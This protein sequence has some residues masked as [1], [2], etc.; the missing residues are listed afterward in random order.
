MLLLC[1]GPDTF[2]AQAKAQELERAFR[3]KY[4]PDGSS[5]EILSAGK[6]AWA[7]IME[8]INTP[9][10]FS[11]RRFLRTRDL[12]GNL[13]KTQ[14]ESLARALSNDAER[15]IVVSIESDPL[16]AKST[17]AL[18]KV[19]KVICY[20]FPLLK[21][22]EFR[23]WLDSIAKT[24]AISNEA[25][26]RQ[27]AEAA[28]GDGWLAWNELLKVAAGGQTFLAP[29]LE[30]KSV[31]EAADLFLRDVKS[32]AYLSESDASFSAIAPAFLSQTRAAIRVR[33]GAT[34]GL[35]PYVVKKLQRIPPSPLEPTL[36]ALIKAM[37]SQR[38][39][40]GTDSDVLPILA[41]R[42]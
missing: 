10:L 2:R 16:S 15:V 30:D 6:E 34:D 22:E 38:S 11:P 20:D 28:D 9:S 39:G 5:V 29:M 27:I 40:L 18:A 3:E 33:D 17:E 1:I 26:I 13:T 32:F 21:G 24:L 12:I 8:R 36:A 4:D 7:E 14:I 25:A 41:G 37:I 35:H 31:F 42:N 19:P 23:S